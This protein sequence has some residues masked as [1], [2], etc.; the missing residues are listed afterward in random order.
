MTTTA[1]T[2][3]ELVK[4]IS[5]AWE[6]GDYESVEWADKEIEF[7]IADGPE[8]G[9]QRGLSDLAPSLLDFRSAWDEYRSEA[10]EFRELGDGGVLVLTQVRGRGRAS[11]A[12]LDGRRANRFRL[13][14][15]KVASLIVYWDRDR[16]L[17]EAGLA[18]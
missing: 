13:R 14:G 6:R 17:V 5:S 7:V 4:S 8:A 15:G 10:V 12:Q 11:G 9:R 1:E 18:A 3:L 16:A 2:N